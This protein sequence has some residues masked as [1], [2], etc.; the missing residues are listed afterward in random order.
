MPDSVT[1]WNVCVHAVTKDLRGGSA[2]ERDEDGQGPHGPAVRPAL[3]ARG[4][5][6]RDQGRREQRVGEAPERHARVR[7]HRPVDGEEPPPR[8]RPR[9]RRVEAL[10]GEGRRR[11]EPDVPRHGAEGPHDGRLQGHGDRGR[12][13][14]RRVASAAR[15]AGPDASRA[16]AVRHA[17]EQGQEDPSLRRPREER[18]PDA[19]ERA[20]GRHGGR[21]ALLHGAPGAPVPRQLPVRVHG[22]DAEPLRLDGH[23]LERLQGLSGRRE[24]GGR[25]VE[26][27]DA[28]RELGRPGPEP[29]DG[30]RG[31]ALARRRPGAAT[32]GRTARSTSSTRASRRRTASRRSRAFARRRRP[33]AGSRGSRAA[34]RRRT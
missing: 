10:H 31:D 5:Q 25:D 4:R 12:P 9:R 32:R 26:A 28:S 33:S 14:G 18:R 22:A 27:D 19:R 11:D 7:D 30:A 8:V 3:P 2:E 23:R 15:S 24:D 16:V 6:G 29:E 34:R 13:L 21:A 1:S 20:D 17:E